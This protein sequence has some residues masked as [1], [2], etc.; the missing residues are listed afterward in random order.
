MIRHS[1][2]RPGPRLTSSVAHRRDQDVGDLGPRE[3]PRRPLAVAE[4]LPDPGARERDAVAVAMRARLRRRHPLAPIAPEGMLE[5]ERLDPELA[6]LELVED[7]LR[8]V[9]AV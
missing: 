6:E 3:L 9:G 1:G 8:V 4:H 7:L 2:R 5:L